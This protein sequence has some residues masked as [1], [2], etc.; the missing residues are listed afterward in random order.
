MRERV[1]TGRVLGH[2]GRA[3]SPD[4]AWEVVIPSLASQEASAP[5][6]CET[7]IVSVPSGALLGR[8]P[9]ECF[10]EHQGQS[11][12]TVRWSADGQA[13]LWV[14]T[15][16]WGVANVQVVRIARGKIVKT[17]DAR[18]PAIQ[19]VLGAVRRHSPAPYAAA[20]RHTRGLGSWFRDGFAIDVR[21]AGTGALTWPL[22][23]TIDV[24][25]DHKCDRPAA[26]RAGGTMAA[27]LDAK[28]TWT[29][30]PFVPG[31]A[32][33]GRDGLACTFSDCE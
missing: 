31:H 9:G 33:C 1:A 7:R 13:L 14:A 24:T 20:K 10:H 17:L 30:A 5:P 8:I 21:P 3:W 29:F 11:Q 2:G 15:N 4:G 16:K 22:V 28:L 18:P 12:V 19:R 25:S 26:E 23:F 27:T 32:G 6:R